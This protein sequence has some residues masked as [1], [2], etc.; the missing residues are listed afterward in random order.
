MKLFQLTCLCCGDPIAFSPDLDQI[1]ELL[2]FGY[3]EP[4]E[5]TQYESPGAEVGNVE[6]DPYDPTS[7][8]AL[9]EA[10]PNGG[11]EYVYP[12]GMRTLVNQ[13]ELAG[14][15]FGSSFPPAQGN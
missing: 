15:V 11:I 13:A 10:K 6:G 2:K 7:I 8:T 12:N 3:G 1:L 4:A 9:F 14:I 5:V